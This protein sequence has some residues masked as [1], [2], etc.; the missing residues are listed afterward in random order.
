MLCETRGETRV[1]GLG[2]DRFM[3][4]LGLVFQGVAAF[5]LVGSVVGKSAGGA[6]EESIIFWDYVNPLVLQGIIRLRWETIFGLVWLLVGTVLQVGGALMPIAKRVSLVWLVILLV[7]TAPMV[8]ASTW[9]AECKA[10][11][12]YADVVLRFFLNPKPTPSGN[13]YDYVGHSIGLARGE[14]E[15][16]T[17][18]V[19]RLRAEAQRRTGRR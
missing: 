16:D 7:I 19:E 8:V 2:M 1:K 10:G 12:E 3:I 9:W 17:V 4:I 18:Y 13:V 15:P 14:G 6:I 11:R 5:L